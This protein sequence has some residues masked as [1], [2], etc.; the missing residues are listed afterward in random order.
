MR[1]TSFAGISLDQE[2]ALFDSLNG[3]APRIRRRLRGTPCS[4]DLI[5]NR[6]RGMGECDP[7]HFPSL[8]GLCPSRC[9][10]EHQTSDEIS[11]PHSLPP[12]LESIT[13]PAIE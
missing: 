7:V 9:G 11:P 4:P 8:L 13:F 12:L 1:C 10:R 2:I 3:S 6:D 5:G